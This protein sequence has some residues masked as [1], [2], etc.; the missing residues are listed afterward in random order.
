MKK[1]VLI[2]LSALPIF[3]YSQASVKKATQHYN[4]YSYSKVVEKLED[5][6]QINTDA[7]RRLAESYKMLGDYSKAELL[8]AKIANAPDKKSEDILAYAQILRMNSKYTEAQ[9]Q[10]D[11]YSSMF[12]NDLRVKLYQSNKTYAVDLLKDKGQ[13]EVKNLAVNSEQQDFGVAFYKDQVVFASSKHD[14]GA[15][16]R[17][18]NGNNLPYLDLYIGKIDDKSEIISTEKL[19][20]I[21]KKYHEG[22][23]SYSKDGSI[24]MYTQDNYKSKSTD[25]IRKLEMIESRFKDGKWGE[26]INFPLNNKEYSVGHPSLS[27][28][29]NRLYFSSDMPGGKGGVDIYRVDRKADGTWGSAENLGAEINTEGNEMF[30]FIHES[31]LFFFSSDGRPGLG[32]LDVF[33][34]Q[35]TDNQFSKVVNIGAPINGSKDD[36]T[37]VL[38]AEKTKG[39]FASNREGGKGDDDLYSFNLL[40][41]FQFGKSIKGTAKDKTGTILANTQVDLKDKNGVV[42]KTVTTNADGT[43]SFDV[44]AGKEFVLNGSKDAYLPG[45]NIANTLGEEDVVIADVILEKTTS[46]SLYALVTD[47][48]TKNA[49]DGVKI[50]ITDNA[51]GKIIKEFI[52]PTSGD[53]RKTLAENKIG[54]QLNYTLKLERDGYLSKTVN[55]NYKITQPGEIKIHETLDLAMNKLEVGGDLATMID[56]KPIYFDLGKFNIRKDAAIELDKIVKVMNDYPKME[57]ELGSHTDCRASAAFNEKLSDNRAKASA[58]YIKKSITNPERISGKG[59]GESKLKNGCACEGTVKSTCTEEEHQQNR[60]TEFI[61]LK[62]Q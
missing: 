9:T 53:Y 14:I 7:E 36:F 56:I 17:S 5:K 28:D 49:L 27:A 38:N 3:M 6:S 44:E 4:N 45:K 48:K 59:Y 15:A 32:G 1:T 43:Y 60:R 39:Y 11:M 57:V 20:K 16:Q 41:P 54:D 13:F 42:L 12:E 21:N 24:V 22:P 47:A 33:V 34:S 61:I 30:P 55:F 8:Y 23:S 25:G 40:K 52:T 35:I 37:F 2:A 50:T 10:M 18:W 19:N 51:T 62:T 58:E 46:L 31:G 26:K 29:G